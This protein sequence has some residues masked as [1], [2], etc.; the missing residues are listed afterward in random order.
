M[1][2]IEKKYGKIPIQRNWNRMAELTQNYPKQGTK[3]AAE[4]SYRISVQNYFS[5]EGKM[6]SDYIPVGVTPKFSHEDILRRH[7]DDN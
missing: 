2:N 3:E 6:P 5:T 7:K 1:R 4:L